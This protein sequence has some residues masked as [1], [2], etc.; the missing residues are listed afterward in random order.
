MKQ[1]WKRMISLL[2]TLALVTGLA[3]PAISADPA[4]PEAAADKGLEFVEIDPQTLNV[5]KLGTVEED[6]A[7]A[8]PEAPAY[9][10]ND[11]VRVSIVLEAP[12][13]LD[14]GYEIQGIAQNENATA[15][16]N[17]LKQQQD[18]LASRISAEVLDGQPLEVKW[19]I[20][21]AG[22]MISAWVPYG[23]IEAISKLDGVADV[24]LEQQYEPAATN[25][26]EIVTPQT[27]NA[28]DMVG[29]RGEYTGA[30]RKIAV[31]DTGLDDQHQSF[32]EEAFLHAIEEDGYLDKLMTAED[33]PA[34]GLNGAGIYKSAKIPYAYNYVDNNTTTNHESDTQE[35]HG[36]H[37]SGIA[38]ANRYLKLDGEF[39]DAEK[40]VGVV[41]QAPDA[42]IF[43]MKVF[44]AGGGAYD[45]DYMVAIEDAMILGA[46]AANLSL[47]SSAPGVN[48][49]ATAAYRTIFENLV[50]KDFN[51]TISMGNNDSWDSQKQLYADDV[52]LHTGG[53]PGTYENAL[54]V[55]S[56]DDTGANAPFLRVPGFD[57][58]RYL[59]GGGSANNAPMTTVAGSYKYVYCDSTGVD[60][61]GGDQFAPVAELV[62]GAVAL[63][64]RGASSFY[65]KANAAVEAGAVATVIINNQAG[66]ISMALDGYNYTNPCV[67]LKQEAR[68]T[69]IAA[70]TE[71]QTVN[72]VTYYIGEIE[73]GGTD[74]KSPMKYYEMSSFSS[75]GVP[76]TLTLKPE[77]TAP[78][79]TVLSLNGYHRA[80]S[81]GGYAGGH[82]AYENMSGTSMAAPEILGLSAVFGQYYTE[83]GLKE[84]TGLPLRTLSQSLLMS[85][86]VPVIE[87]GS[88]YYYSLLKQGAGL[89]NIDGAIKARSYILMDE[90]AT[91]SYA[92]GKVKAELGDDPFRK[93]EYSY[94]FTL[95][96]FGETTN[97][98]T[99]RTDLFTQKLEADNTLMSHLTTAIDADVSYTWELLGEETAAGPDVNKD[100]KVDTAD[101]QAILDK[102]TGLYPE[103]AE[104]DE[105]VA[106]LDGDGK[107][108]T[109]DAYLVFA[110][111]EAAESSSDGAYLLP[112]GRSAK[113]TVTMKLSDAQKA[114]FDEL[115][116][117]GAYIEGFTFVESENDSTHSIPVLAFYG[118]WTDASMFNA[119]TYAEAYYGAPQT[120]YFT[121]SNANGWYMRYNGSTNNT[122]FLGNPYIK[123]ESWPE[124]RLALNNNTVL[125]QA[126]YTLIRNTSYTG[127]AV[128]QEGEEPSVLF[129]SNTSA[130]SVGGAY[131]NTQANTP[132]WAQTTVRN[133]SPNKSVASLGL[134]EGDKFTFGLYAL[135]E[136]Y[137]RQENGTATLS[138][139]EFNRLLSSG[140][141]GKGAYLGYTVTL[142][143]TAPVID[144]ENT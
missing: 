14:L 144:T 46:D 109:Y 40:T 107:V 138:A 26:G 2:L 5:P 91:K 13:T 11:R 70:A 134:T 60:A 135:P 44:G 132:A 8:A 27:V 93:G 7:E 104:F 67:S 103:D 136:Y 4:E 64:N 118:S 131:F 20:T 126:T 86:A 85:T 12:A 96:N 43:V 94:S 39:V 72:G 115:R 68:A 79:G 130:G 114:E 73:V 51:V 89:A 31:I 29:N 143:D 15:Y 105:A 90:N 127:F 19:N 142:D 123:E 33:I 77:I 112:A 137:A 69:F 1:L 125:Y 42:Q 55:A 38:T 74:N 78:G 83:K 140:E 101:G 141:L 48:Y 102:L 28:R 45:S 21:L 30:G 122:W 49:I 111:G 66:T 128:I 10:L 54:T 59:E 53:S 113:V 98:Y 50:G 37:V 18:E 71:S 52:N 75:W 16:R 6:A 106:D 56:I 24:Q 82:D 119:S 124:D 87:E 57:D 121:A 117:G 139:T 22:N 61:D 32:N 88:D 47:G 80:A 84:T 97:A 99:L 76:G 58:I 23:K 34:S 3:V 81:G 41:G 110:Y 25:A 129:T 65:Q 9:G 120:S 133:V 92:D 35:E 63:C 100:G 95:N 17:L 62:K 116:K 108:T 36:S